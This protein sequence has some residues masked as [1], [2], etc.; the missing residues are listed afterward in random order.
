MK[1]APKRVYLQVGDVEPDVDFAELAEVTWCQDKIH[2][3]DLCYVRAG[4]KDKKTVEAFEEL[5]QGFADVLDLILPRL[6]VT[7]KDAVGAKTAR[8]SMEAYHRMADRR[9]V[10]LGGESVNREY[11]TER[12]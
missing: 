4:Q 11:S 8:A 1:N 9:V 10:K 2:D 7:N 12:L 6:E 5:R 3:S